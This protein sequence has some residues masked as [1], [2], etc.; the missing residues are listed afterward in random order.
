M[1]TFLSRRSFLGSTISCLTPAPSRAQS[2]KIVYYRVDAVIQPFGIAVFSRQGVGHATAR[3]A[4]SSNQKSPTLNFE[5]SA[6]SIPERA[7]GLH[8][9][10]YFEEELQ[11]RQPDLPDS[12]YFGFITAPPK[13][14]P[15]KGSFVSATADELKPRFCCAVE[16]RIEG[17]HRR[18]SKTYDAPLPVGACLEKLADLRQDLR[19]SLD[20]IC[21]RSCIS[22]A[23]ETKAPFSFLGVLAHAVQSP[24]HRIDTHYHYGDRLLHFQSRRR[25]EGNQATVEV[26]VSGNSRHCFRFVYPFTGQPEVPSQIE[27]QP[28]PWLRLTLVAVSGPTPPKENS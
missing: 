25:V 3:L 23:S 24:A 20:A 27:Y 10:G 4:I 12:R 18:Y 9:I 17:R 14:N 16:G 7:R 28:K 15:E 8:Q 26:T 2:E 19:S 5:F 6:A 21:A 13:A 1:A 22:G 11:Q